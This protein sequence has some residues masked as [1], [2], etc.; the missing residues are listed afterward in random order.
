MITLAYTLFDA[1][2]KEIKEGIMMMNNPTKKISIRLNIIL[3][4]ILL[5]GLSLVQQDYFA[6]CLVWCKYL[7]K[8]AIGP[9]SHG[10]GYCYS[11][12][13]NVWLVWTVINESLNGLHSAQMDRTYRWGMLWFIVSEVALFCVFFL[14]LFYTRL[15][16]IP[17]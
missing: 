7:H 15:F 17:N 9:L 6:L 14:A 16:S 5:F 12:Y 2:P 4:Q 8:G 13:Y 1:T 3:L 10:I 11:Y